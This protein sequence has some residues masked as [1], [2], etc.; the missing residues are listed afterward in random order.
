ME[1]TEG[2]MQKPEIDYP[3]LWGYRIIGRSEEELR[4]AAKKAVGEKEHTLTVTNQ[5]SGGKYVSLSLRTSVA[6]EAERVG[7]LERLQS[8][9]AVRVV[10]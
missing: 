6:D 2:T 8:S 10:L 7:I 5:S 1:R 9:E 4:L 3:C